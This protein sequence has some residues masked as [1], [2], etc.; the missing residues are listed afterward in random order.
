M[1]CFGYV[2]IFETD[3]HSIETQFGN[4]TLQQHDD[5]PQHA[6]LRQPS[7][8]NSDQY[9][10]DFRIDQKNGGTVV[11]PNILGS[12]IAGDVTVNI[13]VVSV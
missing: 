11:A 7:I 2:F 4:M 1:Y 8:H 5:I 10:Q 3:A 13:H 6:S 9:L 12:K